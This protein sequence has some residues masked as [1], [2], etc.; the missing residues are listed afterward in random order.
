MSTVEE[1]E[2]AIETLKEDEFL[3]LAKWLEAKVADAWDRRIYQDTK[4]GKLDFLFDEAGSESAA[5]EL[6][7]WSASR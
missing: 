7:P 1:I 4:D 6:N 2:S 5:G 3:H